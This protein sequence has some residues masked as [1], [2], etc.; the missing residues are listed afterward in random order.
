MKT[1]IFLFAMSVFSLT[2]KNGFSQN[3]KIEIKANQIISVDE[4][5]QLIKGQ[6]DY[7]FI[8]RAN[9][10]ENYPKISLKKGILKVNKLLEMSLS[11][12][13]FVYEFSKKN[14]IVIKK[15]ASRKELIIEET[16]VLQKSIRGTVV[17]ERG[18]PLPSVAVLVKNTKKG[19]FTDFDGKF[20]ITLVNG[21]EDSVLV[22]S[23][24]GFETIEA[25]IGSKDVVNIKMIPNLDNLDEVVVIGYGTSKIKDAT[26]VISRVTAKDIENAPM[27]A[28][29][30]SLLQGKAAGVSVQVQSASPTSPI[31][32]I[33]RGQSSLSGDNQ[34]LWV[35]DGVPQYSATT[36]GNIANTL[37]NLN[38]DDVKSIDILKDASATAVYGSRAAN[39]VV[40]VTTKRGKHNM[41]PMLEI[42]TRVGLTAMDF[43]DYQLF[44]TDAYKH[45]TIAASRES[46]ISNGSFNTY[47][48][49]FLDENA[50]FNLNTS[51][52]DASDLKVLSDAFYD[53]NTNWQDEMTQN[54]LVVQHN[55]SIRGGSEENTYFV[56]FNY[57]DREGIIK[58]GQSELFGGRLNFDTKISDKITFGLNLNASTRTADDKDGMLTS[59]KYTRPD[60]PPFNPD[61]SI[62]TQD[63]YTE[64]PYTTLEN[65]NT[66]KGVTFNGTAYLDYKILENLRLRSSFTSNYSDAE[67]LRYNRLG[68]SDNNAFNNRTWSSTKRSFEVMESTLSYSKLINNKHNIKVLA[69]YSTEGSNRSYYYIKGQ[70]FPDDD[71]LNNFGSAV[72]ITDVDETKTENALI[73]Q[74]ARVHYKYD[75][76]Y[77]ISGTVRRDGS[78]RFGEDNR[79]GVFPSGAVAWLISE[80]NFMKSKLVI[81]YIS[82]LKFRASLGV[83][84]SQNLGNFDWITI[85]DSTVYNDSPALSPSTIGNPNLGW[86]QTQMFDLGLDFGLLDHRISGSVG[87]YEKKSKDLIYDRPIAWS[88]SFKNVTSNVATISNK[89]FEFD[90][91]YNIIQSTDHRLTFDFNFS[92]NITKVTKINGSLDEI[93]YPGS[94]TPYIRLV[95]GGEIGQWYGLETAGRFYVN[96]ED[97]YG[98]VDNSASTGQTTY[99]NTSTETTGD[100]IFIDQD[101][102]GRITNDDRVNIGSSTPLGFG[103]FGLTYQYKGFRLNTTF[104][105]A[106]GH[107]R[108]WSMPYTDVV[109][110]R[111][112]NQSNLI[113]GQS[114]ILN[115]PYDALYPRMAPGGVG[116]NNKFSDF[117][118]KDASYVRLNA[119]NISYRLP[120]YMF[121]N[122][123]LNGIELTLQGTNLFT[124]TKYPGFDPQG[125]WSSTAIGSGMSIDSSRYPSAQ[126]YSLGVKFKI[127]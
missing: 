59:L 103:G 65:T 24:M 113:A 69:G 114:T 108:F 124:I 125:N 119:L 48:E 40:L 106:Y 10:F 101:G 97:K 85:I 80:E 79:F 56:S 118:L 122:S 15:K 45:F 110:T 73:S 43:N 22:F 90:I 68:S 12:G 53:S 9:L 96:A 75:D 46:V 70:D 31:S 25:V 120:S 54:P 60:L 91:K 26:G 42:S 64:N 7:T 104:T 47:T 20:T 109:N 6:T 88:S 11:K 3:A 116:S 44:N 27:E 17:D 2:P 30:E 82:Y 29:V 32:V 99:L 63:I 77:I 50:F 55:F 8:Y 98:I 5:F 37:Y 51:E 49:T 105:Y 23:Y 67:S 111:N 58:S 4:V 86:E 93:Y 115:N 81:K 18:E 121:S 83:T 112:Y 95:E 14:T 19:V 41:K 66:G 35:I 76:R 74:F 84:G 100:L 87:I 123:A 102:D 28:T 117:Y 126:V 34:P 92:K 57:N 61:G 62:Y 1:F 94:T 107:K 33:I 16:K 71:L 21:N 39:G 89:G 38:L 52:Y 13:A 72:E 78:S 36:S 127:Q